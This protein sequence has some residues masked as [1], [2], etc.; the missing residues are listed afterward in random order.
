MRDET[1]S[2]ICKSSEEI[3]ICNKPLQYD[4]TRSLIL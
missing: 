1:S 3:D 2:E 4:Q